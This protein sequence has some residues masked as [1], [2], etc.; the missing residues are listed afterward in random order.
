MSVLGCRY[1]SYTSVV[2]YKA[3][4]FLNLFM[5]VNPVTL[6]LYRAVEQGPLNI[7]T[8]SVSVLVCTQPLYLYLPVEL[9]RLYVNLV[10]AATGVAGL[11]T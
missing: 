1:V 6:Y 4:T 11:A 10:V 9:A 3:S 2:G 8:S 7:H 5:V